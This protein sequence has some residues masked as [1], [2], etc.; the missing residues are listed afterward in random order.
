MTDGARSFAVCSP[1]QA[2]SPWPAL[3]RLPFLP[4]TVNPSH[5]RERGQSGGDVDFHAHEHRLDAEQRRGQHV[6]EHISIFGTLAPSV[7][8]TDSIRP[9]AA[10]MVVES[11]HHVARHARQ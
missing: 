6:G 4:M 10:R 7:N 2:A 11:C 3:F 1:G 9:G 5:R 8:V